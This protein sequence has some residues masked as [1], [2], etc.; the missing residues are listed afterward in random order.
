MSILSNTDFSDSPNRVLRPEGLPKRFGEPLPEGLARKLAGSFFVVEPVRPA[1]IFALCRIHSIFAQNSNSVTTTQVR[2]R[3]RPEGFPLAEPLSFMARGP[4]SR[5][6]LFFVV[7]PCNHSLRGELADANRLP[8]CVEKSHKTGHRNVLQVE[9]LAPPGELSPYVS[10]YYLATTDEE[11]FED[12]ERADI[13]QYRFLLE[14]EAE[15]T[16]GT[17]ITQSFFP[18]TVM[19]PRTKASRV[20]ARGPVRVF[21]VGLLPAGWAA[22][23]QQPADKH[24]NTLQNA[25]DLFGE[26][27]MTTLD[28]LKPMT[29]IEQ[30]AQ[31]MTENATRFAESARSVPHWFIRAVDAWLEARL[32]P[33][34]ADLETATNLSRRQVERLCRQIYGSPPKVLVRKYRALRTA[35]AIARGDGNWQDFIDE[36]FYD[37]AHCIRE[38]KE[39]VGITPSAVRLHASRLTS[40]TFDRSQLMGSIATLSAQT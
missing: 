1:I 5:G 6:P 2:G 28:L 9:Y 14:G 27:V 30:M 21:G 37:Q 13:A 17:G 40:K 24:A 8:V 23:T 4:Q 15:V 34:I 32:S 35:N 26:R 18:V 16:F 7:N 20:K 22:F 36:G 3:V 29:T 11:S 19:G 33:D 31:V 25:A 38:I 10:A 12:L 39:F